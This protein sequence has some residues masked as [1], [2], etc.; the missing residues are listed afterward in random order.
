MYKDR[1]L[2]RLQEL[3]LEHAN[4]SQQLAA[5]DARRD[6]LRT[7]MLRIEGAIQVLEEE[8]ADNPEPATEPIA[9]AE[10]D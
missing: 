3:R 6:D 10:T 2:S 1:L 9:V 4:G 5:L 7:T 8:L